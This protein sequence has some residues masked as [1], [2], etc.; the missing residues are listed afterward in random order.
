M[1]KNSKLGAPN[2]LP[3]HGEVL[4]FPAFFNKQESDAL[5]EDLRTGVRW[6]QEPIK[7]FGKEIMQPRLTAWYSDPGIRYSY[8]GITMQ[9]TDW[10]V[11]LQLIK[12]RLETFFKLPCNSALLNLYR[13][14]HDS[15][16]WHRDNE[17]ELGQHPTIISV[18]FGATR[19]FQ[20]REYKSKQNLI[21]LE[22]QHGSVL[23]MKGESQPHWEHRVPK[24]TKLSDPRI[25]ITFRQVLR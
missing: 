1:H 20:L 3:H 8:S 15:M 12:T 21:S 2:L 17:K 23:I 4:L 9:G 22:L 6:K 5:F 24:Q 11:S 25:N 18:N 7:L 10:N 13:D 16:G 19:K 14:G